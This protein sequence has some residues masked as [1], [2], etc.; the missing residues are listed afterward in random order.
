MQKKKSPKDLKTSAAANFPS[1]KT[2]LLSVLKKR[3][4]R[5]RTTSMEPEV[6]GR[7]GGGVDTG[8][9]RRQEERLWTGL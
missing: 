8:L 6:R 1:K 5:T 9:V 4:I 3:L 7:Q 2:V